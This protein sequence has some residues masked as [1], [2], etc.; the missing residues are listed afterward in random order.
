MYLL[1]GPAEST[2]L[3]KKGILMRVA[4]GWMVKIIVWKAGETIEMFDQQTMKREVL[5]NE[6]DSYRVG[7]WS[8]SQSP[9]VTR[10]SG[11]TH[12]AMQNNWDGKPTRGERCERYCFYYTPT[13]V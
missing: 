1:I 2:N 12:W 9:A 3:E 10:Y 5:D 7:D 4:L 11:L 6:S 13:L 8:V